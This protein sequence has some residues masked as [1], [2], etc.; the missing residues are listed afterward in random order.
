M[1]RRLITS[2]TSV[3]LFSP[4]FS[5]TTVNADQTNTVLTESDSSKDE[6][7]SAVESLFNDYTNDTLNITDASYSYPAVDATVGREYSYFNFMKIP[8]VHNFVFKSDVNDSELESKIKNV[9]FLYDAD[10]PIPGNDQHYS[11]FTL[12]AYYNGERVGYKDINKI[13]RS[14]NNLGPV[15]AEGVVTSDSKKVSPLV[16]TNNAQSNR[17]VAPITDWYTDKYIVDP[18]SGALSHRVSTTE[19]LEI[20]PYSNYYNTPNGIAPTTDASFRSKGDIGITL[21]NSIPVT[22]DNNTFDTGLTTD[23]V[24]N[25]NGRL[26]NFTLPKNT[27]WTITAISF[28]QLGYPYYQVSNDA[29]V[30]ANPFSNPI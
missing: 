30:R 2:L 6:V 25:S 23:Q 11:H 12:Y 22:K 1:N 14:Q 3:M 9:K 27:T 20:A 29:W 4:L 24:Y 8:L 15:N 13:N 26:W 18:Y 19:W 28:D 17:G 16:D 21:A 7:Q 10:F 5:P